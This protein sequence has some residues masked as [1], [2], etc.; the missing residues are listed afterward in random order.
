MIRFNKNCKRLRANIKF[1]KHDFDIFKKA[2]SEHD[3]DRARHLKFVTEK[4]IKELKVALFDGEKAREM[5]INIVQKIINI[6]YRKSAEEW[7]EK[8]VE[9]DE[10]S[11]VIIINTDFDLRGQVIRELPNHMSIQGNAQ[12]GSFYGTSLPHLYVHGALYL[13][14]APNI[15][16]IPAGLSVGGD[17]HIDFTN[18]ESVSASIFVGGDVYM[19]QNNTKLKNRLE[20]L[21]EMGKIK[22]KIFIR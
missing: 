19:S 12:L 9:I 5:L 1:A 14:H 18:I 10:E 20:Q 17:L 13:N 16:E 2:T 6:A 11:Q 22:G 8:Y 3:F 15:K 7:L 4:W 21:K